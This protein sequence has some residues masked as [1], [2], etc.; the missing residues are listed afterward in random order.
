[1]GKDRVRHSTLNDAGSDFYKK[2]KAKEDAE[3]KKLDNADEVEEEED[4]GDEEGGGFSQVWMAPTLKNNFFADHDEYDAQEEADDDPSELPRQVKLERPK[5]E[6]GESREAK[7]AFNTDI[8]KPER[9]TI[10]R[11]ESREA[12]RAQKTN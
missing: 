9:P 12:K 3:K 6:R 7:R 1:M 4:G 2:M 8:E 5:I 10:Q 11:G